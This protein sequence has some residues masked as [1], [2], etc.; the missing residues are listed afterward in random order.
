MAVCV[1]ALVDSWQAMLRMY[2]ANL[3]TVC[4][5][6]ALA[7]VCNYQCKFAL[8]KEALIIPFLRQHSRFVL[9][10]KKFNCNVREMWL[11][12]LSCSF[13]HQPIKVRGHKLLVNTFLSCSQTSGGYLPSNRLILK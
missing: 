5:Y 6:T 10:V 4:L 7:T 12:R 9:N 8:V 2:T 3:Q 13:K 1:N 11:V